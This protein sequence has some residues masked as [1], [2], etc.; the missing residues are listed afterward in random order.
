MIQLFVTK[1]PFVTFVRDDG[2]V[3]SLKRAPLSEVANYLRGVSTDGQYEI[4]PG[5]GFEQ[6]DR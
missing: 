4:F 3:V 6:G 2:E 5:P 1:D